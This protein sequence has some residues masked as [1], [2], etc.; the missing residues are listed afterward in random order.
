MKTHR[1]HKGKEQ[2]QLEWVLGVIYSN[3]LILLVRKR[4]DKDVK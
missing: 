4:M 3:L 2:L 1:E